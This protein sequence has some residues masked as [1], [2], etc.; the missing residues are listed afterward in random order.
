MQALAPG[1]LVMFGSRRGGGFVLD[2]VL[3][4]GRSLTYGREDVDDLSVPQHVRDIAL[5]PLYSDQDRHL[6]FTLHEGRTAAE[7]PGPYSFVAGAAR[8]P[9][10]RGA[11]PDP[12]RTAV[13]RRT[14][15]TRTSRWPSG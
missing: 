4:V 12:Q 1:S 3:V 15:S 13:G 14:S 5:D 9:T 10:M 6:R 11:S 2:T 8:R 7:G